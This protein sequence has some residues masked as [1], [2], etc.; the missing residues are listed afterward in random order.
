V[1]VRWSVWVVALLTV[2]NISPAS[3]VEERRVAL[4]IGN[5]SYKSLKRLDNG[6]NDARAMAAELKAAGFE[7][8]LKTNAGRKEMHAA[9]GE[10]G[11]K[12]ASGS[13]GLFYYAGHG[14]QSADKN[15]LIPV[16]A[17]LQSEDDL[18]ADAID[19]GKV[20]RAMEAARN[21]LNIVIL[22]ACRDNP[23]PKGG[24]SG[25]RGLAVIPAPTGTF[26]AYATGP[27]KKAEDGDRGGNGVY[28]GELI[29]ALRQPGLK[30]EEVFKK[31]AN[32]VMEKT[33]GKQVPWTQASL[34]G[35]FYFRPQ[36]A[37]PAPAPAPAPA[38]GADMDALF[39]SSV[40][41]STKA[42]EFEAYLTQFPNGTFAGLAKRRVEALKGTQVASM[43]P[44][45]LPKPQ[46]AA[47]PRP[48]PVLDAMDREMVSGR[49]TSVRDAPEAK[50]KV[51]SA[52]PE[53]G[54]VTVTGRVR[55]TNWYSVSRNGQSLGYSTLETLEEPAAYKARK[56]K[57]VAA[58]AAVVASP[59]ALSASTGDGLGKVLDVIPEMK[60]MVFSLNRGQ[61]VS[62]NE[63]VTVS[64]G[65][66]PR[67]YRIMSK[68][69]ARVT[70]VALDAVLPAIGS[71]V[72]N[73]D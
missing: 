53:G 29:K 68:D 61:Y 39:W 66:Q 57:Q 25:S 65:G 36:A 38:G 14:I 28:T 58:A 3:A 2:L 42:V 32:G 5:D 31:A 12:L 9:I 30:I 16:D 59:V 43:T 17:D 55:G 13:V 34:Q 27:G 62:L 40:K 41:D 50:A 10:F 63:T 51:V 26:V 23:L 52:L 60:G 67:R 1:S 4:I 8:V 35:D 56:E 46:P 47:E 70:T 11:G 6:A 73:S 71:N 24:R 15:F 7:T 21:R 22:D 72:L 19:A 54:V 18:D 37:T 33:G 64:V 44:A 48:E 49:K 69:G 45:A 20:M